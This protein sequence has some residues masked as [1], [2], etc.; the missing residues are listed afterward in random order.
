[1]SISREEFDDIQIGDHIVLNEHAPRKEHRFIEI[2]VDGFNHELVG[3]PRAISH[4]T[5]GYAWP[6][7]FIDE[8]IKQNATEL[9]VADDETVCKLLGVIYDGD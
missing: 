8:V 1:M 5:T 9:F 4:S 7:N 6:Y 2:C 3:V